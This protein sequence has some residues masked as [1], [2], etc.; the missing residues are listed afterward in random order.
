[1]PKDIQVLIKKYF[2]I[3]LHALRMPLPYIDSISTTLL[4]MAH[5]T[6]EGNI[7]LIKLCLAKNHVKQDFL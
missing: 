1:M 5:L 7:F 2:M 3:P 4:I 6:I